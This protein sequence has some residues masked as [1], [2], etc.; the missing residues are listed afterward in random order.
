MQD[1]NRRTFLQTTVCAVCVLATGCGGSNAGPVDAG[2]L[3]D[4]VTGVLKYIGSGVAVGKDDE[5]LY[6]VSTIC[7]HQD[8]DMGEEG[9]VTQDLLTCNCHGSQFGMDGGVITGPAQD[10]LDFFEITI[11][12]FGEVTVHTDRGTDPSTRVSTEE[13]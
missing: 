3:D 10:P 2:K 7:T 11:G 6:A 9:T 12:D 4:Y 8:C 1:T 5:G 13:T